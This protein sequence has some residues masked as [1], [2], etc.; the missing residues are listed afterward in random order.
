MGFVLTWPVG[1]ATDSRPGGAPPPLV[2]VAAYASA[3]VLGGAATGFALAQL[4]VAALVTAAAAVTLQWTGRLRPLPERR[5]QVP[6]RWLLWRRRTLAAAAFGLVIGS[7]ALTY[8]RHASAY[9]LAALIVLAQSVE[10]GTVV[11][12]VYGLC[13]GLTLVANW[14]GDRFVGTRPKWPSSGVSSR[15]LNRALAT[16]A[17]ASSVVALVLVY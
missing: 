5:A 6:R 10:A 1:R 15:G 7:G 3:S 12:A 13:R 11:G 8:L 2:P 4:A 14:V 17:M 9:V 16:A